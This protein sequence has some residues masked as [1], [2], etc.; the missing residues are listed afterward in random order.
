LPKDAEL[1]D[2][3]H[4]VNLRSSERSEVRRWIM[5]R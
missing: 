2:N 1:Q 5:P 4:D 3:M